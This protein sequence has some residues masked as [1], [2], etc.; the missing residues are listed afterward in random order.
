L[1]SEQLNEFTRVASQ[2]PSTL[3]WGE[4]PARIIPPM[5]GAEK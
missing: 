4:P 3:I 5:N 1:A 2:S